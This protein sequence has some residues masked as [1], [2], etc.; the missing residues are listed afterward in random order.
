MVA[1]ADAAGRR[2]RRR[3]VLPWHRTLPSGVDG[4]VAVADRGHVVRDPHGLD[5][6]V[7][8]GLG[9]L[10]GAALSDA[11]VTLALAVV[12]VLVQRRFSGATAVVV[13]AVV[14]VSF[15]AAAV[16]TSVSYNVVSYTDKYD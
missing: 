14:P 8:V 6:V 4:L 7:Y 16:E 1:A 9:V 3:T 12:V 10:V 11:L 5:V 13:S 15:L 2:R